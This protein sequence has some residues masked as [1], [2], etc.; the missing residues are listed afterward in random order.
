MNI[1]R[2][3]QLILGWRM[4]LAISEKLASIPYVIKGFNYTDRAG[5]NYKP[6][7]KRVYLTRNASKSSF[8]CLLSSFGV[9]KFFTFKK[10]YDVP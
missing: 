9:L 5:P 4:A 8:F 1:C 10:S 2:N 6:E 7:K 3:N